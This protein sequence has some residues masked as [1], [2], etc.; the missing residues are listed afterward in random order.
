[1]FDLEQNSKPA[2]KLLTAKQRS[3][4]SDSTRETACSPRNRKSLIDFPY[5]DDYVVAPYR[6]YFAVTTEQV[7]TR[8]KD[9]IYPFKG[10]P[11]FLDQTIDLYGPLSIY[12]SLNT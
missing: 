11:L 3:Q 12:F 7:L 9:S 1:M 10:N 8:I 6:I 5:V 2:K 4:M